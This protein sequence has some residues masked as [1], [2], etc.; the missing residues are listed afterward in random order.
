VEIKFIWQSVNT[1][2]VPL[3]NMFS[4]SHSSLCLKM[5]LSL[6]LRNGVEVRD[7]KWHSLHNSDSF[8]AGFYLFIYDEFND[9]VSSSYSV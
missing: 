3:T 5:S 7:V 8:S 9:A 1:R 4:A 6:P 2:F